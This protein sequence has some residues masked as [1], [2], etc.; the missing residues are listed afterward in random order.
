MFA[1][2]ER[3]KLDRP[4]HYSLVRVPCDCTAMAFLQSTSNSMWSFTNRK[5][6]WRRGNREDKGFNKD[7]QLNT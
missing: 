7:E 4:V 2:D 1:N 5:G 3:G 6:N